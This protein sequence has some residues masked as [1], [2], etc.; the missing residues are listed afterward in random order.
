VEDVLRRGKWA[1]EEFTEAAIPGIIRADY[2]AKMPCPSNVLDGFRIG[3]G[4]YMLTIGIGK[5]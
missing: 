4:G 5:K 3:I 1:T 2:S